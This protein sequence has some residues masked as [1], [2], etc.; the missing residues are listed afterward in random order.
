MPRA[1]A[2]GNCDV[3]VED[4]GVGDK[5]KRPNH[6]SH[7][8]KFEPAHNA[9]VAT[10]CSRPADE[11]EVLAPSVHQAATL[12]AGPRCCSCRVFLFALTCAAVWA[13]HRSHLLSLRRTLE[14]VGDGRPSSEAPDEY[15]PALAPKPWKRAHRVPNSCEQ[16]F[17]CSFNKVLAGGTEVGLLEAIAYECEE[18]A[19]RH[20]PVRVFTDFDDTIYSSLRSK[21]VTFAAGTDFREG[22]NTTHGRLYAGVA[23]LFYAISYAHGGPAKALWDL[24]SASLGVEAARAERELLEILVGKNGVAPK[25]RMDVVVVTSRPSQK[26]ARARDVEDERAVCFVDEGHQFGGY[27]HPGDHRVMEYFEEVA[28]SAGRDEGWGFATS[29]GYTLLSKFLPG[30]AWNVLGGIT[31]FVTTLD[32]ASPVNGTPSSLSDK[33]GTYQVVGS[34]K[35]EFILAWVWSHPEEAFVWFGDNGQG[36][37]CTGARLLKNMS[38]DPLKRLRGVFIH[39]MHRVANHG[40]D[41]QWAGHHGELGILPDA[42]DDFDCGLNASEFAAEVG[43]RAFFF[44][45]YLEAAEIVRRLDIIDD[46]AFQ[47]VLRGFRSDL[48]TG[49]CCEGDVVPEAS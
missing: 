28:R 36:D 19:P 44:E 35:A 45:N 15:G 20:A 1:P 10:L 12:Q 23:W 48:M 29:H 39:D 13:C 2:S 7:T 4:A 17:A 8:D 33:R 40:V 24:I 30:F 18:C 43:S 5:G 9:R 49:F 27:K 31:N 38:S 25:R 21:H 41:P 37:L 26:G 11:T 3:V 22:A 32:V 34:H 14:A 47:L 46:E 42:L 16:P 6:S